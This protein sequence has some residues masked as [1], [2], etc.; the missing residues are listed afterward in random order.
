MSI[1]PLLHRSYCPLY[2]LP[3]D[4]CLQSGQRQVLS[5]PV[6]PTYWP[7]ANLLFACS[8]CLLPHCGSQRLEAR[9]V[10]RALACKIART[11]PYKGIEPL[12]FTGHSHQPCSIAQTAR[13]ELRGLALLGRVQVKQPLHKRQD[14]R[15]ALLAPCAAL[16]P[17]C[18][19]HALSRMLRAYIVHSLQIRRAAR[20]GERSVLLLTAS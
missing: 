2:M 11:Q 14:E 7:K 10:R 19:T 8:G 1:L 3:S 17:P 6:M 9:L 5:A 15:L 13:S 18:I 12:R 16:H 4:G 20:T